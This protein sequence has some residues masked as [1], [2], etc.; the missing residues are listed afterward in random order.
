MPVESQL[1]IALFRF[2]HSGNA[3]GLQKVANWA[4]VGKGTVTVV[5]RRVMIAILRPDFM[6]EAVRMLTAPEKDKAKAWVQ[7]HSC[8]AWRDG[9]CMVDGTLVVLFDRPFWFGESY[10][11]RKCN[12]SLNIQVCTLQFVCYIYVLIVNLRIGR[13]PSELAH[14]RLWL[15]FHG[16]HTRLD[17]VGGNTSR[18]GARD[19]T[20]GRGIYLGRL[21][22]HSMRS[23]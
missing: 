8:K 10:F 1:A 11:D 17:C 15:W 21:G 5:T 14:Y 9:W 22:I 12:Y 16:Q 6:A 2:G 13:F 19:V 23:C 18:S 4:G 20:G 7:N 3:A